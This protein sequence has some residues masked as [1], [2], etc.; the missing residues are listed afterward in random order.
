MLAAQNWTLKRSQSTGDTSKNEVGSDNLAIYPLTIRL[1]TDPSAIIWIIVINGGFA[2]ALASTLI[3][4]AVL[5]KVM[6]ATGIILCLAVVAECWLSENVSIFF[7]RIT[8][9]ILAGL[10]VQYIID[11]IAIIGLVTL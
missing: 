1:L 3:G 2:S 4:Y 9:I 7:S 8:T 5:P 6:I 11:R 10:S